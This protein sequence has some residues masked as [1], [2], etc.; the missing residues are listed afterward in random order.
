MNTLNTGKMK[1]S[2]ESLSKGGNQVLNS[3]VGSMLVDDVQNVINE[4]AEEH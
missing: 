3:N 1:Q 4:T 2:A